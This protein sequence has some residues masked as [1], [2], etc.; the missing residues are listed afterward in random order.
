MVWLPFVRNFVDKVGTGM[1]YMG[2][3][4]LET[5]LPGWGPRSVLAVKEETRS[6]LAVKEAAV[7]V[8]SRRASGSGGDSAS[9]WSV[10]GA[11]ARGSD[12]MRNKDW[13]RG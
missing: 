4:G 6:A 7:G 11:V 9:V 2:A 3:L 13:R 5:L 1:G 10:W 12:R 8:A